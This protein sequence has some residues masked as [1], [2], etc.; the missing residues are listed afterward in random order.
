MSLFSVV[1]LGNAWVAAPTDHL[2]RT[3]AEEL[4]PLFL[5]CRHTRI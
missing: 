3:V 1:V 5:E 4:R 2:V